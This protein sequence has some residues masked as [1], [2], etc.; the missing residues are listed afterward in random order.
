M[1]SNAQ[2]S[3]VTTAVGAEINSPRQLAALPLPHLSTQVYLASIMVTLAMGAQLAVQPFANPMMN[4]LETLGL[5]ATFMTQA[6]GRGVG[7]SLVSLCF[8]Y[9]RRL[10]GQLLLMSGLPSFL[11]CNA[12]DGVHSV[13][14]V[15]HP[16]RPS[17]HRP[18]G[19]QRHHRRLF[20]VLPGTR[21]RRGLGGAL[22]RQLPANFP[23]NLGLQRA[24]VAVT[25]SVGP[26]ARH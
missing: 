13:L 6:R 11:S 5:V 10:G 4:R 19:C 14:V 23:C 8:V 15:G 3:P 22:S 18:H 20:L 2:S 16:K 21:R 25:A 24:P 12:P 9:P 1:A 17:D 7:C 26:C